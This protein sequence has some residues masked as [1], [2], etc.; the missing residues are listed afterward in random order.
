MSQ[1]DTPTNYIETLG[2]KYYGRTIMCYD[3]YPPM[4]HFPV[5][6]RWQP[7]QIGE[8]DMREQVELFYDKLEH[9]KKIDPATFN[10]ENKVRTI[11]DAAMHALCN[12]QDFVRWD[13]KKHVPRYAMELRPALPDDLSTIPGR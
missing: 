5:T 7:A 4:S 12:T 10:R 6:V 11:E 1:N 8:A 13:G 2:L 3:L 9:K